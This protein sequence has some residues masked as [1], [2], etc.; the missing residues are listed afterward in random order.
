MDWYFKI[1]IKGERFT[2]LRLKNGNY[3]MYSENPSRIPVFEDEPNAYSSQPFF[4]TLNSTN[5]DGYGVMFINSSPLEAIL[6]SK[7]VSFIMTSGLMDFYVLNGPRP[8]E[9]V[10]QLQKT[11]GNPMLPPYNALNWN[12]NLNSGDP[13]RDLPEVLKILNKWNETENRNYFDCI[14]LYKYSHMDRS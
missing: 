9:I 14:K 12:L 10:M 11:L 1:K 2:D 13:E 3:V 7:S 6:D 5:L 8:R 4:M